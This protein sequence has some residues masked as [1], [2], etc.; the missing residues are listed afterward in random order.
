[1]TTAVDSAIPMP[2]SRAVAGAGENGEPVIRFEGVDKAFGSNVVYS[3]M[4]LTIRRG[5]TITIIGGSGTGKSVMLK[6]L[7]GLMKPD[8]G[9]IWFKDQDIAA[10]DED[11]LIAVRRQISMLFQGAALFDSMSVF[12][13]I[14]YPLREHLKLPEEQIVQRVERDLEMVGL[15]GVGEMMPA[16]LSGGMKKRVGLAR[17]IAIEPDVILYDEPTTGLDPSNTRRINELIVQMQRKLGVTS[18]VVTHD[19]PSAFFVSNRI[20]MLWEHQIHS[21]QS[22]DEI[23]RA[24]DPMIRS[25]VEGTLEL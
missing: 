11:G 3:G 19:M 8:A 17:A 25:F 5:E 24:G 7:M 1:M 9:S 20:A 22:I 18:I 13:N 21:V 2:A 23:E 15:R 12:D 4:S 10:I 16:E 6:L 14:A